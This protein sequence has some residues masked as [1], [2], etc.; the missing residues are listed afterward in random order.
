MDGKKLNME[1]DKMSK[2][3]IAFYLPQYHRFPENDEWW[4]EG[5]T[6]WINTKK[7]RPLF[8]NHYQPREPLNNNYYCLLDTKSQ[9]WQA[10]LAKKYGVYGFC[11]YHYW[12]NGKLLMERPLEQMLKHS[13]I[14]IPFCISW[15]NESWTRAWDGGEKK[16]LIKQ[17][18][19][20]EHDWE[21]HIQYLFQ[22]FYDDR[23]IKVDGAPLLLL[24][25]SSKI[26]R[27]EEMVKYWKTRC[28]EEGFSG[29]FVVETINALNK[30]CVLDS[31]DAEAIFEPMYTIEKD[32]KKTDIFSRIK[33]YSMSHYGIGKIAKYDVD[34]AYE[35]IATRTYK[36][37][38]IVFAGTFPDWDN[39]ARK[40]RRATIMEGSSPQK[41][42]RSLEKLSQRKDCGEYIFVNAWNEWA[43][44]AYLEPDTK[45]K[46]EYLEQCLLVK[47]R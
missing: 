30:E 22:F 3:I 35:K 17:T 19:N 34:E 2:K 42:G 41:F 5:F 33:R 44:G 47:E 37:N 45:Y 46:Y 16:Y 20:G 32:L 39:T 12:F 4:G 25:S 15:A 23:Y 21:R 8:R 38:K 31:S 9:I 13:E 1:S 7:A 6:E 11:Y 43:E 27:C 10:E 36:T 24:Y 14:D 28:K 26:D 18:Y 40:G 29:L